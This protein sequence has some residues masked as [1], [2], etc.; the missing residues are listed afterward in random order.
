VDDQPRQVVA[1]LTIV[2]L[3]RCRFRPG[4]SWP[5]K[6]WSKSTIQFGFARTWAI[7]HGTRALAGASNAFQ[8]RSAFAWHESHG[9]YRD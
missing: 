7:S 5:V 9:E 8:R 3:F 1:G 6:N 2:R 4:S